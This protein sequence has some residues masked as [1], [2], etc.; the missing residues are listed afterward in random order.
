[1]LNYFLC[2]Y[3][4]TKVYTD[5]NMHKCTIVRSSNNL[6]QGYIPR[7][8]FPQSLIKKVVVDADT[9]IVLVLVVCFIFK[10]F[11]VNYI[12]YPKYHRKHCQEPPSSG[13]P[14]LSNNAPAVC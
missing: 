12:V 8:D 3:Q 14:G 6:K 9:Q 5:T 13:A 7:S 11:H 1:M 4:K 10:L 2:F